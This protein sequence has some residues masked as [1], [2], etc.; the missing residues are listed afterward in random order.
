M[1]E[2]QKQVFNEVMNVLGRYVQEHDD[3]LTSNMALTMTICTHLIFSVAKAL[4]EGTKQD[5]NSIMDKLLGD[6]RN[7]VSY[8]YIH[9]IA[10]GGENGKKNHT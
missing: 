6:L 7:T 9:F 4:S 1:N 2:K 10:G 5:F 8:E 3:D